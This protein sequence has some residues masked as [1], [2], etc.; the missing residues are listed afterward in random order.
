MAYFIHRPTFRDDR[1]GV[2]VKVFFHAVEGSGVARDLDYWGDW[3][4]GRISPAGGKCHKLGT[5]A[6]HTG[7]Y[8]SIMTL[9]IH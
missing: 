2:K 9:V 7:D 3:V 6:N 8:F 5:A 1:T 4:A